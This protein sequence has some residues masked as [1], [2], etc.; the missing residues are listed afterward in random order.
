[1]LFY[2]KISKE[3]FEA[4]TRWDIWSNSILLF[5]LSL[6]TIRISVLFLPDPELKYFLAQIPLEITKMWNKS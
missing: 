5:F 3:F 1:M 6:A 4:L 2:I